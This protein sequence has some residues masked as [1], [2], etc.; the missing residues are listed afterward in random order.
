M[1]LV[2]VGKDWLKMGPYM[3]LILNANLG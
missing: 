2:C 3:T 1:E